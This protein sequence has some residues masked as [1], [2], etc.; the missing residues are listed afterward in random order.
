MTI[1]RVAMP[2]QEGEVR[3]RNFERGQ[4]RPHLPA[5]DARGRALHP[6]PQAVLR[7]RLP[8]PREHPAVHQVPARGRPAVRGGEP[9]RRQR[10]ALRDRARLPAGDASARASASAPRRATRSPSAT[11]SASSRTGRSRTSTQLPEGT[12]PRRPAR[13]SASWA[14]ARPASPPPASSPS[15]GHDVTVFEAFHAPGGV[16]IYGIPEFRLPK[17]I[18]QAEV[19]RLVA[20]GVKIEVD[21]IIGRTYTVPEL[22][23]DVRRAVPRRR[24]R[25]AGVHERPGRELQG[26][27]LG[28]RVPDPRQPHGRL[29]PGLRDP[30]PPRPARR[31]RRRRQRRHGRG[32]DRRRLGAAEATIVYRRSVDELPAR[33]EEVH[34]ANGRGRAV[35]A[36]DRPGGGPR[37]REPL[38]HRHAVRARWSSASPTRSGRRRPIKIAG[39]EHVIDCDLVVVAIGTRANPLLTGSAPELHGQR[40]RLHASPTSGA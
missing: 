36:P 16:L 22:R 30:G 26:R 3:A 20:D 39:S 33:K 9:A 32:P 12:S 21:A 18:V 14:P 24:R 8:G 29:E 10:P 2:E 11:W 19:D 4:P 31:R 13:R 27:L 15:K 28:Q 5:R 35:R 6:V 23:E 40:V 34:H 1:D 38:G 37:R 17:D 25:P 7:R